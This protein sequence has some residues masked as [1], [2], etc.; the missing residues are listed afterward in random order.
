MIGVPVTGIAS[1]S[2]GFEVFEGVS[3]ENESSVAGGEQSRTAFEQHPSIKTYIAINVITKIDAVLGYCLIDPQV[4]ITLRNL[5]AARTAGTADAEENELICS[6]TETIDDVVEAVALGKRI[7]VCTG[8]AG[9]VVITCTA[10]QEI[11]PHSAN[12]DVIACV[13]IELT[14]GKM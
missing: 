9:H 2:N 5:C 3:V 1:G 7:L 4:E 12:Q 10:D 14:S 11:R 6:Y 8:S 13:A